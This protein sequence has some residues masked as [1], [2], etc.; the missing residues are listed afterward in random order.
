MFDFAYCFTIAV[1]FVEIHF[2]V[3]QAKVKIGQVC[4]W[5]KLPR[6]WR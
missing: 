3:K 2:Q 6:A 4:Y 5:E 1:H